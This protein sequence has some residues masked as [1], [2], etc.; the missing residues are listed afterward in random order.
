MAKDRYPDIS[1]STELP[2][3]PEV[4]AGGCCCCWLWGL[5]KF[6]NKQLDARAAPVK[7]LHC[8]LKPSCMDQHVAALPWRSSHIVTPV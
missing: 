3:G 1:V 8:I 4:A 2:D 5:R 7:A 6:E